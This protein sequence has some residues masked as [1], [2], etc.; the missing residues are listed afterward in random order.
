MTMRVT[1]FFDNRGIH[2]AQSNVSRIRE[3]THCDARGRKKM[4]ID[5]LR[6]YSC[7]RTH[8]MQQSTPVASGD[9]DEMTIG[10]NEMPVTKEMPVAKMDTP[11]KKRSHASRS[12]KPSAERMCP[13]APKKRKPLRS[14]IR[15]HFGMAMPPSFDIVPQ[16]DP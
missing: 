5:S 8:T 12:R 4:N 13:A 14:P 3:A 7:Q 10:I 15:V 9:S 1:I 11:L 16:V 2:R 6:Y